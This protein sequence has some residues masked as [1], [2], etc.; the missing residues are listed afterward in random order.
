VPLISSGRIIGALLLVREVT[1]LRQHERALM[2]K[3]ATIREIH[4]RVKN[5]LQTVAALLRL[6]ARRLHSEEARAALGESVRRI[7]SIALVH[8]TLSE[9]SR[10]RVHFIK[11][12]KRIVDMLS[13]G[14]V[15]PD[16]PIDF[17]LVGD[18]DELSAEV[19]TP[20]ALVLAELLQNCVEHAFPYTDGTAVDDAHV[21]VRFAREDDQLTVV[22]A[23]NG[24]GLPDGASLDDIANLGLRIART[25]LESELGGTFQI[26]RR[27][28]G[29]A[30]AL[31][32]PLRTATGA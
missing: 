9:E 17:E 7:T 11:I 10:Q 24:V 5:N 20:L 18:P 27:N 1:E 21:E 22:V 8:E 23:D 28:T 32:V 6:Q 16:M 12:A 4:H 14:L 31:C 19:A 13:Q 25:L 15:G 26:R 2:V 3:D 30:V 29:T